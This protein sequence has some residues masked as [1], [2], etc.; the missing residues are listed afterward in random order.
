M[1]I[2]F[3]DGMALCWKEVAIALLQLVWIRVFNYWVSVE[4]LQKIK[5]TKLFVFKIPESHQQI[6]LADVLFNQKPQDY[7]WKR[8]AHP[9]HMNWTHQLMLK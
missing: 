8:L 9:I 1:F 7:S 6:W 5:K 3:A 2:A 4:I